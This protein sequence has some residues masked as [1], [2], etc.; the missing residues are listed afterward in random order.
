MIWAGKRSRIAG[1]GWGNGG[2]IRPRWLRL[3]H[4][5]SVLGWSARIS[6]GVSW[7]RRASMAANDSTVAGWR[8]AGGGPLAAAAAGSGGASSRFGSLSWAGLGSGLC[9]DGTRHAGRRVLAGAP[10]RG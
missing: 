8:C 3:R 5:S 9:P 10:A 1:A 2:R 6:A 7:P 4:F